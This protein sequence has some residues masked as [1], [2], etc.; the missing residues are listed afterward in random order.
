MKILSVTTISSTALIHSPTVWQARLVTHGILWFNNINIILWGPPPPLYLHTVT[1]SMS[2]IHVTKLHMISY[3]PL[4]TDSRMCSVIQC[5][6][7]CKKIF[8]IVSTVCRT[9]LHMG[10]VVGIKPAVLG[11]RSYDDFTFHLIIWFLSLKSALN[12]HINQKI[13]DTR[14]KVKK[15]ESLI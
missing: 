13:N 1:W 3:F 5:A 7:W 12:Q 9:F 10:K 6:L 2:H 8:Y 15:P 11:Q 4:S 14:S